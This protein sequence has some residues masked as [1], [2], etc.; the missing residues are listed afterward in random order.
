M[1][2]KMVLIGAG[3]VQFTKGVLMNLLEDVGRKW[4]LSLVDIEAGVLDSAFKLC[5]KMIREKGGDIELSYST[6]RCDALPGADYVVTTIGVGGRRAWEQDVFIP[7]KYGVYQPVGDTVMPGGI[8]RAMRMIP[9]ML[10]ITKD[11]MRL[12][13]DAYYFNYSNPMSIICRAVRKATNAKIIGLCHG[14]FMSEWYIA[15]FAGLKREECSSYYAGINHLTYIYDFRHKGRDVWPA[16]REKLA[17]IKAAGYDFQDTSKPLPERTGEAETLHEPFCWS[18]FEDYGA[19]PAPGDFHVVEFYPERFPEGKIYGGTMGVDVPVRFEDIIKDGDEEFDKI[20]NWAHMEG[21]L[22]KE[23]Y[24]THVRE[25]L[26]DMIDSIEGDK[27]IIF[28]V[29]V[30]ND[31]AVPNLPK[32]AVLEIPAAA[33]GT[34]FSP[35]ILNNFPDFIAGVVTKN[36]ANIEVTVEAALKGDRKLF[37]EAILMGGYISDRNEVNKMVDELITAHKR[38]LPQF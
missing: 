13:P 24:H 19:Y 25:K 10:D 6:D 2:R 12:C 34:G 9:A 32:D 7:R 22:P 15:D 23:A 16:I 36:L 26:L 5:T 8:S 20:Q 21:E 31:G 30:P 14:V 29:N 28:P 18:I 11:V 3:S 38:Y 37:A 17:R 33:T 27:R 35:I 1:R 4:H